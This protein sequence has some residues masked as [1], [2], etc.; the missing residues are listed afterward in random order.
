M[1]TPLQGSTLI[2]H[3]YK[4][5]M[6]FPFLMALAG[7]ACSQSTPSRNNVDCCC[8]DT[9]ERP[10]LVTKGVCG[11][12]SMDDEIMGEWGNDAILKQFGCHLSIR[13]NNPLATECEIIYLILNLW[14]G[15]CWAT[16]PSSRSLPHDGRCVRLRIT[17]GGFAVS[18]F[19]SF[20]HC[21][22]T[23]SEAHTL[24]FSNST[25]CRKFGLQIINCPCQFISS[26]H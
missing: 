5:C 25:G 23:S 20:V 10:D 2:F 24:W 18:V 14:Y 22:L 7:T 11:R 19:C 26:S 13:V 8:F 12:G 17:Q 3:G 4:D 15:G 6:C 21:S 16:Q 9:W 1:A